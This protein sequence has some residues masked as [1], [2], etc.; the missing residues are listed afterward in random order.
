MPEALIQ[1]LTE[2]T[3]GN[4]LYICIKLRNDEK[5]VRISNPFQRLLRELPVYTVCKFIFNFNSANT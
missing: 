4:I 3:A 5:N 1:K 2:S